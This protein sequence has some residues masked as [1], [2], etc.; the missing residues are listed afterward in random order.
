MLGR[1]VQLEL[2]DGQTYR[3]L[4]A[5]PLEKTVV[6]AAPRGRILAHDG[7]VLAQDVEA[8]ALAVHYRYLESPPDAAWLRRQARARLSRSQRRDAKQVAAAEE[9]VCRD[10]ADLHRRLAALCGTSEAKW[11]RRASRIQSRVEVVAEAVN[12]GR[13]ARFAEQ[14][15]TVPDDEPLGALAI[16]TGLFSPPQQLPPA[17][18]PVAEQAAYHRLVDELP[19]Q[20]AEVIQ[21]HPDAYPGVKIVSYTRRAYPLESLASNVL[22]HVGSPSTARAT[23][24]AG[25]DEV[26]V[27]T[28]VGLQGI[29]REHESHLR[30]SPGSA[31]RL[32]SRGGELLETH[33]LRAAVPGQDVVLSLDA[34]LQQFAEQLLD[35][36]ARHRQLAGGADARRQGGA[37][38]VVDVHSGEVLTA[39]TQPRFDPNWFAT[40]D[41]RV[42]AVLGDP[43]QPLFDR[44]TRMAIPPGSVFKPL[45]ALALV[46][47]GVVSAE[48]PFACQGFLEV[49]DRMRCQIFRQHG[50]GHGDV[51]LADALAQSCNVYFFHHVTGLGAERLVAW[52]RRLGFGQGVPTADGQRLEGGHVPPAAELRLPAA[53]QATAVG[54][55]TLTA[56][57]LEV[58]RMF[59]AIANGGYLLPARFVREAPGRLPAGSPDGAGTPGTMPEALSHHGAIRDI[60]GGGARGIAPRGRRSGRHG[61]RHGSYGRAGGGWQ[62]RHGADGHA[63][64]SRLVR[65]LCAGPGAALCAGRRARRG[66]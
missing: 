30:G 10:L 25:D 20:V 50:I 47:H 62:D 44:A 33:V 65:R 15:S 36:F 63:A 24:V 28:T 61:V 45:V 46:E 39:A 11:R 58:V 2:T 34:R 3:R 60:A 48:Q 9:A 32:T 17:T 18:I 38:L 54:Q 57:P 1:A 14:S 26:S 40:G 35:R 7:T 6:L 51:T 49:P 8:R 13:R 43:G 19:P 29:E 23:L 22:G 37:I 21:Q 52:T 12:R 64:R 53:L 4:A 16:L 66:R 56:T 41:A 59:A 42:E 5:R 55:G 27:E 31:R